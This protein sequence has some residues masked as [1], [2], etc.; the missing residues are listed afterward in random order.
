[1]SERERRPC[2]SGAE[3]SF[4]A[5]SQNDYFY[6]NLPVTYWKIRRSGLRGQGSGLINIPETEILATVDSF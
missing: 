5:F 4:S 6:K 1:M 3:K 2:R